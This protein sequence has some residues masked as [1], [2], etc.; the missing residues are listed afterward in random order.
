MKPLIS[1][2][3]VLNSEPKALSIKVSFSRSPAAR[4]TE[5]GLR[6]TRPRASGGR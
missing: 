1:S 5:A 2:D 4:S 6:A 3:S